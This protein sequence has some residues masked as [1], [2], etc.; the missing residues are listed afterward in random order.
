MTTL[1]PKVQFIATSH[2]PFIIQSFEKESIIKLDESSEILSV[3]ATQLSIEDIAELIQKI[4]MPQMSSKKI[5]MLET[6]KEYFE[7]LDLLEKNEISKDE[8]EKIKKELDKISAL[9]DDNMAYVAFLQRKRL[10]VES[11]LCDL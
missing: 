10:I 11:N 8:V 3:D 6:A 7:K 2:S 5:K 1:F 4:D 9:Y